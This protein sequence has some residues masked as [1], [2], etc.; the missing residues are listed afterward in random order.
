MRGE[1][2]IETIIIFVLQAPGLITSTVTLLLLLLLA[3]RSYS[4]LSVVV[5]QSSTRPALQATEG[6][7]GPD[8]YIGYIVVLLS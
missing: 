8:G 5:K 3:L 2:E 6:L 4:L 7:E 1:E